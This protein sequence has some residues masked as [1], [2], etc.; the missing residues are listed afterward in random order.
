MIVIASARHLGCRILDQRLNELDR[1]KCG[2]AIAPPHFQPRRPAAGLPAGNRLECRRPGVAR[3]LHSIIRGNSPR[4]GRGGGRRGGLSLAERR[5]AA[6][7]PRRRPSAAT[8]PEARDAGR[9][10]RRRP[11]TATPAEHRDAAREPRRRASHAGLAPGA[12]NCAATVARCSQNDSL[13]WPRGPKLGGPQVGPRH[14]GLDS[15]PAVSARHVTR[16]T[17]TRAGPSDQFGDPAS[18]NARHNQAGPRA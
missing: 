11:R 18:M 5:D 13:R 16:T 12:T 6:R 14:D 10:P 1:W 4:S 8:P 2:G 9:A 7:A 17:A 3:Q 15:R